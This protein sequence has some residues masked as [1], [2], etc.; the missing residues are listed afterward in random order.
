[1]ND[2]KY[3]LWFCESVRLNPLATSRACDVSR[4]LICTKSL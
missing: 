4:P 1:M 2:M 3:I